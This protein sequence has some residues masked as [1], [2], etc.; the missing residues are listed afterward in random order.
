MNSHSVEI[1]AIV[2]TEFDRLLGAWVVVQ[3]PLV[4]KFNQLLD[5]NLT[6]RLHHKML[7][8]ENKWRAVRYRLDGR[9]IDFGK[10][11]EVPIRHL[12]R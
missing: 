2:K 8:E 1:P 6:F 9:M 3:G 11:E 12:V 4:A 10:G 7:I 5:Q